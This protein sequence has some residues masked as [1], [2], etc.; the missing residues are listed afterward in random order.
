VGWGA[1]EGW[2]DSGGTMR[3]MI[4]RSNQSATLLGVVNPMWAEDIKFIGAEQC[5]SRGAEA[6]K[7]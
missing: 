5:V 6:L 1:E 2:I 7:R 3:K 4:R